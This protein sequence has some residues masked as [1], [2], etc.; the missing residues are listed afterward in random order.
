MSSQIA[1]KPDNNKREPESNKM[2]VY[3]MCDNTHIILFNPMCKA[4]STCGLHILICFSVCPLGSDWLFG[5]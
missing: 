1:V 4:L 2:N 5:V 3:L